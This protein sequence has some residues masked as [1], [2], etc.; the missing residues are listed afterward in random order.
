MTLQELY[1]L[2]FLPML[3]NKG[4]DRNTISIYERVVRYWT[5]IVGNIDLAVITEEHIW[6]FKKG[7][8]GK[9]GK[10]PGTHMVSNTIRKYIRQL[11]PMLDMAGPKDSKNKRGL[12]ILADV[13]E[14]NPPAEVYR[15]AEDT[16]TRDEIKRW[17]EA[18]KSRRAS[19]ISGVDSSVWWESLLLFLYNTGIRIGAVVQMRWDWIDYERRIIKQEKLPGVKST[20]IA[21]LNREAMEML[22]RMKK[23]SPYIGNDDR[24]FGWDMH[25]RTL[26]DHANKQQALAGIPK[27][28]RFKFHAIRKYFGSE[29]AKENL[30][31]ATK[32]L[33][34]S[35]PTVTARYYLNQK[36]IVI[37][38]IAKIK[39]LLDEAIET[40]LSLAPVVSIPPLSP[41]HDYSD[42][43]G[44][45]FV[46]W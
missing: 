41:I 34:H 6:K 5:E 3:G 18:A 30:A 26:Y 13:P 11:A 42:F 25:P 15:D 32:A 27:D 33:G 20:Y 4:R 44:S 43:C 21:V 29:L 8:A 31:V 9:S 39:P 2:H 12:G 45:T 35:N 40:P 14:L 19:D 22:D 16:L 46:G 7:L 36:Q 17:I 37:P 23:I 24:V 28:R 1:S 38:A 10:K